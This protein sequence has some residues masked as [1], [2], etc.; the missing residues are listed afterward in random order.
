MSMREKG[1]KS[2]PSTH[3]LQV[4]SYSLDVDRRLR[5]PEND[6]HHLEP[7][8]SGHLLHCLPNMYWVPAERM[9]SPSTEGY[10]EKKHPAPALKV[11]GK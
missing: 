5:M 9:K 3:A 1:T 8:V 7:S 2:E 4:L 11:A 10:F 6:L